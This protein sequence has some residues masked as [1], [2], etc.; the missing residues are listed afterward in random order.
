MLH[1]HIRRLTAAMFVETTLTQ[2]KRKKVSKMIR[3]N[4]VFI[5]E[6]DKGDKAPNP[7][8]A[9]QLREAERRELLEQLQRELWLKRKIYGADAEIVIDSKVKFR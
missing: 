1:L 7:F 3:G 8:I 9:H 2:S 6:N 5:N 4:F